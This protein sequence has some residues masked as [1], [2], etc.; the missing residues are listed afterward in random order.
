VVVKARA[1][2]CEWSRPDAPG[3]NPD[4]NGPPRSRGQ[5]WHMTHTPPQLTGWSSG[6]VIRLYKIDRSS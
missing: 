1:A 5:V 2:S 6:G 3:L 4:T